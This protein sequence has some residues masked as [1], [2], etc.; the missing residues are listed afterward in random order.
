MVGAKSLQ[1]VGQ[2]VEP[3]APDAP[4]LARSGFRPFFLL[5]G[6]FAFGILPIWMLTLLGVLDPTAYFDATY[7]HAHEMV[8]GFAVAVIAGFLLTAVGNWTKRTTLVGRPLLGLAGLWLMGRVAITCAGVLPRWMPAAVDLAFLPVL[9]GVLARP[10]IAAKNQRNFVMLAILLALFG[11]NLIMH[12]DVLGVLPGARL[13]GSLLG[14]DVVVLVILVISG[15]VFPMFTRNATGVETIR[16]LPWLDRLAIGS[17]VGLILID[18]FAPSP[19]LIAAVSGVAGFFAAARTFH[20]GAR[21]AG[22]APLLWVLHIGYAWIPIGLFLRASMFVTQAVSVS[23]A[24]H[25][26]TVGAIGTLTL[27]MMSRVTLGHTGR[28]LA[29]PRSAALAFGLVTAAALVRVVTPLL[30]PGWA[31]GSLFVAGSAWSLAFGLYVLGHAAMLLS[32]R[33][34]GK[35]G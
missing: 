2:G 5:A 28:M 9:A 3:S 31:R 13:K 33:V 34:D 29:A 16:S 35:A 15:R 1:L 23:S 12:L 30:V 19:L 25:A 27:G 6:L 18:A 14:V 22:S 4:P 26:F 10:L 17:M 7:W 32:P 21:H 11:A 20:W 24:M 8:F